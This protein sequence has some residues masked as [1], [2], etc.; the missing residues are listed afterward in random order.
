[1]SA[2]YVFS[3]LGFYPVCPGSPRY[4]IG[5]PLVESATLH[6]ENGHTLR[7]RAENQSPENVFVQR[8]EVNGEPIARTYLT[9]DELVSGGE[10]T[11]LM[12]PSP[13]SNR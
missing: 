9:H 8:V 6:L 1:M 11:F 10:I 4:A 5:S 7:I 2:W 3:A 12:G 13:G